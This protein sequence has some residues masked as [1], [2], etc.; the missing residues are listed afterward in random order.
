M[1]THLARTMLSTPVG[2]KCMLHKNW[3]FDQCLVDPFT[4]HQTFITEILSQGVQ[5]FEKRFF[6]ID[7][8]LWCN[9]IDQFLI[10][11]LWR[12]ISTWK[13]GSFHGHW[14]IIWGGRALTRLDVSIHQKHIIYSDINRRGNKLPTV[15]SILSFLFSPDACA[16]LR[17]LTSNINLRQTKRSII[18]A[19]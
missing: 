7:E 14:K 17:L 5:S 6:W 15:I 3:I 2:N 10:R 4:M 13:L 1:F 16:G 18:Y 11:P 8:T 19:L 9:E 12:R